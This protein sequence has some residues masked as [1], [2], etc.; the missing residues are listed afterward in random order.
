M[1]NY[2]YIQLSTEVKIWNIIVKTMQMKFLD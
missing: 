1:I 2:D